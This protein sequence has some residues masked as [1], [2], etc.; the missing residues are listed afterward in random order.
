MTNIDTSL[1]QILELTK[2]YLDRVESYARGYQEAV[3]NLEQIKQLLINE[4]RLLEEQRNE[5]ITKSL[6]YEKSTFKK[7]VEL[8]KA[9]SPIISPVIVA[10]V[11]ICLVF[12]LVNSLP[13]NSTFDGYG[14]KLTKAC[15]AK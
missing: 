1:N 10:I 4:R 13:C 6:A 2:D 12:F 7:A 14:I 11:V 3:G 15:P 5:L 9:I 8:L